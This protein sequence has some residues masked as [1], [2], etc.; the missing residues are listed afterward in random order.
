MDCFNIII[1]LDSLMPKLD[2]DRR[3]DNIKNILDSPKI[4]F[5]T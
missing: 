3:L 5:R 2:C 1:E 4:L